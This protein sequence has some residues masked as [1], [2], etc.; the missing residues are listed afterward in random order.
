MA[1]VTD[2]F[3]SPIDQT[4]WDQQLKLEVPDLVRAKMKDGDEF[5]W[6]SGN[7]G[8]WYVNGVEV[9]PDNQ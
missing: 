7:G 3:S 2:E 9:T 5:Q 1:T 8:R 4:L 6:V